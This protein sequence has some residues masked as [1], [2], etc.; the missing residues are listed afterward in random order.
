[1]K[2]VK[3]L[4][5]GVAVCMAISASSG[6]AA[7][8]TYGST[9]LINTPSADV[10]RQGQFYVGYYNLNEGNSITVGTS[11][12][13]KLEVSMAAIK[14]DEADTKTYLNAKYAIM[15]EGVLVPGIAVGIEDVTDKNDRTAYVAVS[16]ALP[17][18]I[19]LHAGYGNGRY[20][21]MFYGLEKQIV[22]SIVGGV[23]PDT[24]LIIEHDGHD[25]NYGLRM[26]LVS[27]LKINA[28][29]RDKET[30]VGVT[31]NFY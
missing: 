29:W 25:M 16:K 3:K 19:R 22:P 24:S 31:Y 10:V 4:L 21:G 11:L 20:D 13:K 9:G 26:S 6:Q 7:S 28:G 18:G 27:G 17:F 15:Q 14:Y 12:A 5:L 30:Y 1:M 23:F 2:K 8:S